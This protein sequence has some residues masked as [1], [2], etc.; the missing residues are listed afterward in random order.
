MKKNRA[1]LLAVTLALLGAS[2]PAVA[3]ASDLSW[4]GPPACAQIEPLLFQIE[5]ALGAPLSESGHV[6]LQVHV[7]SLAPDARALLRIMDDSREVA[8]RERSLVAPDCDKLVDTLAVAI[9]LAVEAASPGGTEPDAATAAHA[10]APTSVATRSPTPPPSEQRGAPSAPLGPS[11]GAVLRAMALL[12]G[13]VGSLPAPGLGLGLGLQLAWTRLQLEI[14]GALWL[15]QHATLE[16]AVVAGAGADVGLATGSVSVCA[17]P[18]DS[19]STA[20]TLA[21]CVG[22]E[23][24]QLRGSGTGVSTPRSANALWLAPTVHAG[25][26]WQPLGSRFGFGA[27]LGAGVP[28]ERD[29]FFLNDLGDIHQPATVVGRAAFRLDVALE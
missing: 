6:H 4:S 3:R 29:R 12:L 11:G 23:M 15:E 8:L 1:R 21:L 9:T 22:W 10:Q 16:P 20:L 5:R 2:Q 13:D 19:S 27:H 26:T 28:L 25:L 24:G 18:L 17:T 14:L 7:T